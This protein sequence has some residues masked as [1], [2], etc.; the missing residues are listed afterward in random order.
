MIASLNLLI[1]MKQTHKNWLILNRNWACSQASTTSV[2]MASKSRS[3][4]EEYVSTIISAVH[5]VTSAAR[6]VSTNMSFSTDAQT[7]LVAAS[8]IFVGFVLLPSLIHPYW[9]QIWLDHI[10]ASSPNQSIDILQITTVAG[11]VMAKLFKPTRI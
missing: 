9:R 8:L 10:S 5:S 1:K 6:R 2:K 11:I 4:E 7:E 3:I